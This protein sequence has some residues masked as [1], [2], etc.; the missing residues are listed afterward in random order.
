M[1]Q[2]SIVICNYNKKEYVLKCIASVLESSFKDFDIYVVDNA[3]TDGS[4]QA[5]KEKFNDEV[6]LIENKQNLGGSGGFNTGIKCVINKGYKYIY[7]LDNDVIIDE[8]A[9]ENLVNYMELNSNIGAAGSKIYSLDNPEIVQE[10]GSYID[11]NDFN[12]RLMNKGSIDLKKEKIDIKCDYVPAC[13]ALFRVEAL[14]KSG[15]IDEKYF[16]Y[17]DDIDLGYRL[18]LLGYEVSAVSNSKVWHKGGGTVRTNT[19][20]TYY[21]W[22]NRVHFFAKYI[23]EN[24]IEA[25]ASK[26]FNEIFQAV[27]S[28][29][30]IGKYSSARTIIIAVD[31]ALSSVR[32]KTS[33]NKILKLEEV[34]DRFGELVK[35][36]NEVLI[37]NNS[38]ITVLRGVIN[39]I[40]NLNDKVN[41][42][43]CSQ[44]C[45]ELKEQFQEYEVLNLKNIDLKNCKSVIEV[46]DHVFDVRDNIKDDRI[47]V[48]RFFNVIITE[49]DRSYVSNYQN[50][51]NLLKNVWYPILVDKIR[52]LRLKL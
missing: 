43:L 40:K 37:L 18:K 33:D 16:V 42:K 47:Y 7:L 25:F 5:I 44:N 46:C 29:N 15:I 41:I 22:R 38:S 21:F 30:Y 10:F 49:C 45:N 51:Y 3:S 6:S 50:S 8:H 35:D 12:M 48:D 27:Y 14:K 20:G 23:N 4:V 52:E 1:K 13:S 24:Q 19:F 17:W 26:I 28:C 34:K 31:D 2:V 9:L 39:K 36:K 11:F 32:G